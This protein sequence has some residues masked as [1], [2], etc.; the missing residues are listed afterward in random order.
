MGQFQQ[1]AKN[2]GAR[3]QAEAAM[4]TR[5]AALQ[6]A[7]GVDLAHALA[8][9]PTVRLQLMGRIT[10]ALERERLRGMRRHWT[11]DLNR[12]IALK[13]VLDMLREAAG[14]P[15]KRNA[16]RAAKPNGARRRRDSQ[17]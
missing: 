17:P 1:D 15:P 8:A 5:I 13:Q 4:A 10:R 7:C 9:A 6:L 14:I 16:A 11:Y 12:H 3:K 2:F